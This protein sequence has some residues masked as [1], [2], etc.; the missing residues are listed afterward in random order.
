[1]PVS[2][3]PID[4]FVRLFKAE[5]EKSP[6]G[7]V[8]KIVVGEIRREAGIEDTNSRMVTD[9]WLEAVVANGTTKAGQYRA[10]DKL[11]AHIGGEPAIE[12]SDPLVR[13]RHLIAG[14]AALQEEIASQKAI[15]LGLEEKLKKIESAEGLLARL[16]ELMK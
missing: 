11:L 15:L 3:K 5:A 13:A 7:L 12:S 1:M 2:E 14:K 6:E 4:K 8:S 16:E 10:T 9:G